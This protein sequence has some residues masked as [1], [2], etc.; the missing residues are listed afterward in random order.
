MSESSQ[1]TLEEAS[2]GKKYLHE[3]IY[4]LAALKIKNF[5]EIPK[6]YWQNPL[7]YLFKNYHVFCTD[8]TYTFQR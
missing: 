6:K 3:T 1:R 8:Q 4:S 5:D 2:L 7:D